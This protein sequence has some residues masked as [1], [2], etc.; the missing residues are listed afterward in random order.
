MLLTVENNDSITLT[1]FNY[2]FSQNKKNPQ[3]IERAFAT[4]KQRGLKP[5]IKTWT[6]RI[7]SHGNKGNFDKVQQLLNDMNECGIRPNIVTYTTLINCYLKFNRLDKVQQ[8]CDQMIEE[9][10]SIGVI[11]YSAIINAYIKGGQVAKAESLFYTSLENGLVGNKKYYATML[12]GYANSKKIYQAEKLFNQMI[13]VGISPDRISYNIMIKIYA[14]TGNFKQGMDLIDKMVENGI[15]PDSISFLPLITQASKLGLLALVT[16]LMEVTQK[17]SVTPCIK[18][19]SAYLSALSSLGSFSEAVAKLDAP[20]V[21]VSLYNVVLSACCRKRDFKQIVTLQALMQKYNVKPDIFT[22]NTLIKAHMLQFEVTAAL[23]ILKQ[24]NANPSVKADAFSYS[25]IIDH[26]LKE[27]NIVDAIAL[28]EEMFASG[29]APDLYMYNRLLCYA[30]YFKDASLA[31][32]TWGLIIKQRFLIPSS[33]S[34]HFFQTLME[35]EKSPDNIIRH[36]KASIPLS[37]CAPKLNNLILS[38]IKARSPELCEE[39][40]LLVKNQVTKDQSLPHY[41]PRK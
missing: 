6:I 21:D 28:L 9:K 41:Q 39:F 35:T 40:N 8:I 13:K 29:V 20:K 19:N 30:H 3:L 25:Q 37:E 34:F 18:C 4:I 23:L 5:D 24:L 33:L 36:F 16:E 14:E 31:I 11:T 26:Y 15:Q 10:L 17:Y 32:Y 27:S 1:H 7:E 2:F 38:Y 22:Y 12:N